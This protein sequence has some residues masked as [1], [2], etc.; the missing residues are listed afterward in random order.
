MEVKYNFLVIMFFEKF[1]FYIRSKK[2]P[3]TIS[4]ANFTWGKSFKIQTTF[5]LRSRSIFYPNPVLSSEDLLLL[6]GQP[7]KEVYRQSLDSLPLF[8][9]HPLYRSKAH[10]IKKST[11][12]KTNCFRHEKNVLFIFFEE[13]KA[14]LP[15]V[16][17]WS[18][19][20]DL[21]LRSKFGPFFCQ[22]TF[23]H[24]RPSL[25]VKFDIVN[26]FKINNS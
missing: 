2:N 11:S 10:Y 5:F 21:V 24:L 6:N 19:E 16:I 4:V 13:M 18:K 22:L 17:R 26:K 9:L 1:I 3:C 15:S 14:D 12:K 8:L 7:K 20:S 25:P 23:R